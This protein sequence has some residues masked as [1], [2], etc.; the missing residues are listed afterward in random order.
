MLEVNAGTDPKD[1]EDYPLDDYINSLGMVFNLIPSGTFTMGSP[2][3]EL[4]RRPD[5]IQ[6]MV[7][8]TQSFYMQTTEVTQAQWEAI[9][10]IF[11][12]VPIVR[13]NL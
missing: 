1:P 3:S 10:H 13:L 2:E 12:A 8:L 4:G 7:T 6:H 9:L 11:P 5:E